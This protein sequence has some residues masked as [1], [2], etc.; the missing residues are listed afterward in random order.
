MPFQ[1]NE[2]LSLSQLKQNSR[3]RTDKK[4]GRQWPRP[5]DTEADIIPAPDSQEST[6]NSAYNEKNMQRFSFVIGS[7]SLRAVYFI[8]K[9]KIFGAEV[10]LHYS[11]FLLKATSL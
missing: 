10:F 3:S 9:W 5:N 6:L 4:S 1:P 8:G 11:H 7:F 2:L